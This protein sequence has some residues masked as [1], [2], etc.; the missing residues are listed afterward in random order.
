MTNRVLIAE[1]ERDNRLRLSRLVER[2]GF[3]PYPADCGAEAVRVV[4]TIPLDLVLMELFLPD[5]SALELIRTIRLR[6][7]DVPL[8]V[9]VET[10]SKEIRMK[11]MSAGVFAVIRKPIVDEIV[12]FTIHEIFRK[13]FSQDL[14]QE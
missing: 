2:E 12:S 1:P 7:C 4:Q 14:N 3:E 11:V 10:D 6:Q 9:L 8:V 13:F 5:Y